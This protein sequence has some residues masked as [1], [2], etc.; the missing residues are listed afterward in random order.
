M[1]AK[2]HPDPVRALL[3]HR[4]S[5]RVRLVLEAP[6]PD[7]ERLE[8]LAQALVG[9]AGV[10][11][12]ELR[13]STGSVILRHEGTF[14]AILPLLAR[15]GLRVGVPDDKHQDAETE[16]LDPVKEIAGLLGQSDA[17][18]ARL[19]GGRLDLWG[20][21]FSLLL[22]AGAVQLA[23]GRIAGPALTLFGQAATLAMARPLRKFVG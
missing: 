1:A 15:A 19:T 3:R 17:A 16:P 23:R 2:S 21:S 7:R 14:E 9:V 10:T 8:H 22:A 5:G 12:A 11:E 20:A 13:P 6:T 4:T 18:L